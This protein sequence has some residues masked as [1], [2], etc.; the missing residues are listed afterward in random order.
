MI[1]PTSGHRSPIATGRKRE[2]P[3]EPVP[4][5]VSMPVPVLPSRPAPTG[6]IRRRGHHSTRKRCAGSGRPWTGCEQAVEHTE[7]RY[8]SQVFNKVFR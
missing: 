4:A 8:P 6:C 1:S 7:N 2:T 3:A 5:D